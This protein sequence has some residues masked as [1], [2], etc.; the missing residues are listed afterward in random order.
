MTLDRLGLLPTFS[1]AAEKDYL[2]VRRPSEHSSWWR[3]SRRRPAAGTYEFKFEQVEA[4]VQWVS[5]EQP[6]RNGVEI[7]TGRTGIIRS[8]LQL[9]GEVKAEPGPQ[10]LRDP[11]PDRAG[12]SPCSR[13]PVT[14]YA[15][16]RC[17]AVMTSQALADQRSEFLAAQ[18]R[19]ALAR[20]TRA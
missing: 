17:L 11:T 8:S 16:A 4:R 6:R 12:Q 3:Q 10:R 19:M 5:D 14:R 7:G 13:I 9:L 15:E 2:R 18:K 1:F 20:T